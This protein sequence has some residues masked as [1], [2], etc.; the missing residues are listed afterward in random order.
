M[1]ALKFVQAGVGNSRPPE[2]TGEKR[3][4]RLTRLGSLTDRCWF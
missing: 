3:R 1:H 2:P 4:D